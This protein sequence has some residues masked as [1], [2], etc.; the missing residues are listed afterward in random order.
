MK[1]TEMKYTVEVTEED[2][3]EHVAKFSTETDAKAFFSWLQQRDL[4]NATVRIIVGT[5]LEVSE[6][7]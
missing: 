3:Q 5:V 1:Y 4:D 7:D 6:P 2:G